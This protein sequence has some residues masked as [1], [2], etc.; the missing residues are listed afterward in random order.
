MFAIQFPCTYVLEMA[1]AD[2]NEWKTVYSGLKNCHADVDFPSQSLD[3]KFRVRVQW[4]EK[5]VSEPSPYVIT[6]RC[7]H[8]VISC[9]FLYNPFYDRLFELIF[10]IN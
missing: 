2:G 10:E 8:L 4:G 7:V 5:Y 9:R 1:P 3:Y 6:N